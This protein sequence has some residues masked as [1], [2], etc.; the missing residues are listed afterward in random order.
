[1]KP[2]KKS[3]TIEGIT[4]TGILTPAEPMTMYARNGDPGEPGCPAEFEIE[5]ISG[6]GTGVAPHILIDLLN[7]KMPKGTDLWEILTDLCLEKLA[8]E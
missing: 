2:T 1:M 6:I 7:T 8:D 3:V 5:E 4:F